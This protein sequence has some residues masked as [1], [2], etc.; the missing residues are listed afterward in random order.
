MFFSALHG[1][2]QTG[3]KIV[4]YWLEDDIGNDKSQKLLTKIRE[5]RKS[6]GT[7]FGDVILAAFSVSIH[8]YHLRVST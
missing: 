4:S 1:P 2:H 6:T 3:K 8:R 5:I 7:G